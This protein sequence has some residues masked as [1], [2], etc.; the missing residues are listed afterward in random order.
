M[1]LIEVFQCDDPPASILATDVDVEAL[2]TA[3]RGEYGETAVRAL[4]P[5]QR[6][7]FLTGTGDAHR[8]RIAPAVRRLVGFRA[9]NLARESWPVE[10][11][12]DVILCRN[13]LMYLEADRRYAV[14][15]RIAS[16]LASDGLVML[17]PSE[18]PGQAGR[19]FTPGAHGVYSR[20]R[21][22]GYVGRQPALPIRIHS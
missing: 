13:A 5:S 9:L 21:V 10:G 20:R 22:A 12:F 11:P 14:L 1:T 19:W 8:W 2:A 3:E 16:L 4:E 18:H 15:E 7:R 6:A 17:D